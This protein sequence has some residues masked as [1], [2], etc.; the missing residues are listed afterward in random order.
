MSATDSASQASPAKALPHIRVIL[1]NGPPGSGKDAIGNLLKAAI[2]EQH[3]NA[4]QLLRA[5]VFKFASVLKTAALRIFPQVANFEHDKDDPEK[6]VD[7]VTRRRILIQLSEQF[8]KPLFGDGY[9]GR[10]LAEQIRQAASNVSAKDFIAIVTDSGFAAEAG[11][12]VE[13]F[14]AGQRDPHDESSTADAV[15]LVNIY[16]EGHDF[17][18]DSRGMLDE[19]DIGIHPKR[20]VSIHNWFPSLDDL[21]RAI[22]GELYLNKYGIAS[23]IYGRPVRQ[24][25]DAA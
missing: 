4:P 21:D 14:N 7:G 10:V 6:G 1:L 5:E 18:G 2:D 12:I 24:C 17:K 13:A 11:E 20:R 19:K 22:T 8:F 16:R 9:F 3:K 23:F 15:M 25:S